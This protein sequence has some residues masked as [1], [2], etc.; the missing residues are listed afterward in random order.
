MSLILSIVFGSIPLLQFFIKGYI[1][2]GVSLLL[3]IISYFLIRRK[4][5]INFMVE[6]TLLLGS[7]VLLVAFNVSNI[8]LFIYIALASALLYLASMEDR[9]IDE[10]KKFISESGYK[11]DNYEAIFCFFGLGQVKNIEELKNMKSAVLA[12]GKD[13]IAYDVKMET[14]DIKRFIPYKDMDD[15]GMFRLE[16]EQEPYYQKMWELFWPSSRLRTLHKPQLETFGL[17]FV[18]E[19]EIVTFYE[20]PGI[21]YKVSNYLDDNV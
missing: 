5:S 6:S 14:G 4:G 18:V 1:F 10:L 15:Y 9:K 3:L 8:F 19:D 7:Q 20:E 17:Y 16:K 12:Y 2:F 13:G 11:S 21:L